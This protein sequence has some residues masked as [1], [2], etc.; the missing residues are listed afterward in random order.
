MAKFDK[1]LNKALTQ[2]YPTF[3]VYMDAMS[4][5]TRLQEA[6]KTAVD[7]YGNKELLN[8]WSQPW[9][10][11]AR[12]HYERRYDRITAVVDKLKEKYADFQTRSG[13]DEVQG[14][15]DIDEV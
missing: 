4:D 8:D 11:N 9:Y 5:L 13:S 6:L 14:V 1:L 15:Q 7:F 12:E 2:E 3:K 10:S